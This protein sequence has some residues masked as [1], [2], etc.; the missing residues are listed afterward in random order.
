MGLDRVW[1][2]AGVILLE[3][4]VMLALGALSVPHFG[5]VGMAGAY[6]LANICVPALV[7]PQIL[8]KRISTITR[9]TAGPSPVNL[10][11]NEL[12]AAEKSAVGIE[13]LHHD[14]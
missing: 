10:Q 9:L 3:N 1:T 13:S 8:S 6:L 11:P 5:A 7:L 14:Y 2:V 12:N 4:V